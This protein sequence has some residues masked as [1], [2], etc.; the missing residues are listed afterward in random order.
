MRPSNGIQERIMRLKPIVAML[1]AAGLVSLGA[2][3]AVYTVP[4]FQ[5]AEAAVSAPPAAAPAPVAPVAAPTPAARPLP[6]FTAIVDA[7]KNAVVNISVVGKRTVSNEEEEIPDFGPFSD[8]FHRFQIPMPNLPMRGQGS[9][10]IVSSDGIVLTNA[11]VV[12]G[13]SEVTVRLADRREFKAKVIGIDKQTDVAVLRIK[14][15]GL[16]TVK[17]GDPHSVRVGQWVLAIGSPYGFENTVTAGIV[18]ATSRALPDGSYVP[19]I[20]TDAAVNPGNSGGPLFNMKGEVIGINSQIYSRT[21]GY[22]GLSFAIPI[23]VAAHVKDQLVRYGHVDRGR[24]GVTIQEVTQPLADSFG[25]DKPEGAL[26]SSVDS[27]GPA[28]KAGI[29]VG[30]V[31]LAFNGQPIARSSQL[32]PLVANVKP[33]TPAQ[34]EIWRKGEKKTLAVKVGVMSTETVAQADTSSSSHGRLG[35]AVSTLVDGRLRVDNVSGA[36]ARAGI[37]PGDIIIAVNGTRVKSIAQ[38]RAQIG[39]A[40]KTIALLVQRNDAKIFIPVELG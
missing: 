27:D 8:F 36:A 4:V 14:A 2:V 9:G 33:G 25:L 35:V 17:L 34:L 1:A 28:A 40:G 26:V 29:A 16:P 24:I 5:R 13:A 3:G 39:K 22:Q 31:I 19:F 18:S 12:D 21:G 10:F 7:N 15:N 6:D 38:L 30:D 32:P 23:D 37:Q 11:H 20:Q